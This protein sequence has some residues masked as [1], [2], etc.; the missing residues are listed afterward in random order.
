MSA[1]DHQTRIQ[2]ASAATIDHA[3]GKPITYTDELAAALDAYGDEL[4]E[5]IDEHQATLGR[6]NEMLVE[7]RKLGIEP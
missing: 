1:E 5:E 6:V 4:Q 3:L 7:A 2:L